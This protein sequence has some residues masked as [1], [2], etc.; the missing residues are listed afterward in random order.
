MIC[1]IIEDDQLARTSL[2]LLLAQHGQVCEAGR[3]IEGR[4]LI[5]QK[6]FDIV[7]V[8][9][10]LE[11][12]LDGMELV[13]KA[14]AKGSYVVVLSGHEE[15]HYIQE[16]YK[17]G[18]RDYLCKPFGQKELDSLLRK[19]NFL[20]QTSFLDD[21]FSTKYITHDSKTRRELRVIG[22]LITSERP[23]LLQGETGTGKT[24]IAKLIHQLIGGK[25]FVHLNC[26]A[27][28][29]NL[30]ESELFG[31]EK[32]AFSGADASKIG[33]LSLADGGILFLDEISTM[34]AGMQKKLLQV[35]ED[36]Y[37][38]PL[39]GTKKICSHFRLISACCESL[40]NLVEQKRFRRDLYYRIEGFNIL[41]RPLRERRVDIPLLI[42]YFLKKHRRRVVLSSEAQNA[43][44]QYDW[45]GNARQLQRMIEVIVAKDVG[46]VE[47]S[48]L[49]RSVF[50]GHQEIFV[51]QEQ[52]QYIE[53]Q[54]WKA[55]LKNLEE[56]VVLHF[57]NKADKKVRTTVSTMQ[58]SNASFYKIMERINNGKEETVT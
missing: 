56:E 15:E 35:I 53:K 44:I 7:F 12:T 4:R 16:A 32:G 49:P 9:L 2:R 8:D 47:I 31:Y 33:K 51:S 38:Y 18:C 21:F 30:L 42:N 3:V 10:D 26:S 1:L 37:F 29:E 13:Q 17:L 25:N 43:L 54:G 45:P 50:E 57:W 34:S 55:F 22:E 28:P 39:G 11:Q 6:R 14:S 58:I 41:L 46:I 5:E 36:G 40:E 24:M 48:D 52:L 19:Y 20:H 23:V 27:I